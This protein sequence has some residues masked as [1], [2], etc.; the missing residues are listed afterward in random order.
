MNLIF[1]LNKKWKKS[2]QPINLSFQNIYF[3]TI[4]AACIGSTS[5]CARCSARLNS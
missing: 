2:K 1:I 3:F 4:Y 5:G